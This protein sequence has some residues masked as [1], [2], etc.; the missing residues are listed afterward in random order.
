M[1]AI[2]PKARA[3]F[4]KPATCID[5]PW[6]ELPGTQKRTSISASAWRPL[7][8][9]TE[10]SH[11]MKERSSA[12]LGILM[13]TTTSASC[14]MGAAT[15]QQLAEVVVGIRIPRFALERSFM[16]CDRSVDIVKGLQA[17]AE[18]DVRFCVPGSSCHG[19]SI[20]V[21]GLQKLA[22]AFGPLALI[23]QPVG[24]ANVR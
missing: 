3:S 22:R 24:D 16:A 5:R 6:H 15:M 2:G 11:A 7:T 4:C 18:I 14:C 17:D 20:Q 19:L 23:D 8:M 13:P 9:S 1:R 12:N 10:R 21:A